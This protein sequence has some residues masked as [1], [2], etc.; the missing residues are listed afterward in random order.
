[1]AIDRR[2]IVGQRGYMRKP[3]KEPTT[4]LT[5]IRQARGFTPAELSRA[6]GIQLP[7]LGKYESGERKLSGAW[8]PRLAEALR[9]DVKE[10]YAAIGD[11]IP[12][13][14]IKDRV[15]IKPHIKSEAEQAA[16]NAL[17]LAI[18]GALDE[19]VKSAAVE[20]FRAILR[21]RGKKL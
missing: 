13:L 17:V 20:A 16:E 1:M 15:Q 3:I 5:E 12:D 7:T 6:A 18:W 11:P 2:A 10:F 19:D 4:R 8:A 21:S 14:P 9:V